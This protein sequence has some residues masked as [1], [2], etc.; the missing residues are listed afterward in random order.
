[1]AYTRTGSVLFKDNNSARIL[2]QS[3]EYPTDIKRNIE[4]ETFIFKSKRLMLKVARQ[5]NLD[6]N[7]TI[8]DDLRKTELYTHSPI[9]VSFPNASETDQFSFVAI[10]ISKSKIHLSNFSNDNSKIIAVNLKENNTVSTPLGEIVINPSIYYD[11]KYFDIPITI[12]KEN[13]EKIAQHYSDKLNVR[14]PKKSA[15][16][17]DISLNDAP[18]TRNEDI[19]NT[20]IDLYNEEFINDKNQIITNTLDF[21]NERLLFIEKELDNIDAGIDSVIPEKKLTDVNPETNI[22]IDNSDLSNQKI[23]D[24]QNKKTLARDISDYIL[25][26]KRSSELIPAYTISDAN[27][28]K[29]ITEYNNL[30][31]KRS[32]LILSNSDE[33]KPIADLN[34]SITLI[35]QN[36]IRD[37]GNFVL[38]TENKIKN[39]RKLE[40]E[41]ILIPVVPTLQTQ[42][43]PIEY[44]QKTK[45]ALYLYLSKKRE[46][47]TLFHSIRE[48]DI[49]IIDQANGPE[50]PTSPNI[51]LIALAAFIAGIVLPMFVLWLKAG[52]KTTVRN[53][54]DIEDMLS[55]PFFGDIPLQKKKQPGDIAVRRNS[56][57]PTSEAFRMI[58]ANVD[59]TNNKAQGGKVIMITSLT[60]G[61]GKTFTSINLAVSFALVQKKVALVDLDMRK[62]TLSSYINKSYSGISD[63]LSGKTNNINDIIIKKA[64][65]ETFDFI[66]AGPVPQNP[67]ELLFSNRFDILIQDL[68]KHYDYIVLDSTTSNTVADATIINRISDLTLFVIRANKTDRRQL[69]ELEKQYRNNKYNHMSV[70][71][72]GVKP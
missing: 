57:D 72:N 8:N 12:T 60:P 21:I 18:V 38:N 47:C 59:S 54:N 65:Y 66:T 5:L 27:I 51:T 63:F 3:L 4:N 52:L 19:I 31:L 14:I 64:L 32:K 15:S 16:V 41:K 6:I 29:Q 44:Q 62:G 34:K 7:Y 46:D 33:K 26:P 20:I 24:L 9:T 71:L 55:M 45:E 25:D 17:I 50:K 67:S 1:V 61:A 2:S 30:I 68:K 22:Q 36:I 56:N 53:R 28:E 10:P 39:I 35:K 40:S 70:I 42:I 69:S 43:S 11:A 13:L 37:I 58:Q 23:I 49:Q 48:N